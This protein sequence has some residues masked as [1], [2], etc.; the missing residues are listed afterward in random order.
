MAHLCHVPAAAG[1]M[2]AGDCAPVKAPRTWCRQKQRPRQD[3]SQG[4]GAQAVLSLVL[5]AGGP[6]NLGNA[7]GALHRGGD[8]GRAKGHLLGEGGTREHRVWFVALR[9]REEC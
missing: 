1:Q 9:G 3:A 5:L 2:L 6:H 8:C 4:C 7:G